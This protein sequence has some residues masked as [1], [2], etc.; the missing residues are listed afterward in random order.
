MPTP[1]RDMP[2]LISV[3]DQ[4]KR[5]MLFRGRAERGPQ[6]VCRARRPLG[7]HDRVWPAGASP[8]RATP[9]P[10]ARRADQPGHTGMYAMP[11]VAGVP[12]Q[13]HRGIPRAAT[14]W[15]AVG[16]IAVSVGRHRGMSGPAEGGVF[17]VF[18]I[19]PAGSGK[20]TPTSMDNLSTWRRRKADK[21]S[22]LMTTTR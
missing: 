5:K 22:T 1:N 12:D 15:V 19:T 13:T 16:W 7:G 6:W 11:A 18:L 4:E 17:L 8:R 21:L 2:D 20:H 3:D 14:V 9:G 10:A